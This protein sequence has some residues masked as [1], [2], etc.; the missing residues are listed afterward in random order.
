MSTV[1]YNEGKGKSVTTE[2]KLN[3]YDSK[4]DFLNNSFDC[5][6]LVL[7]KDA[8]LPN[9]SVKYYGTSSLWW[10][11]ARFNGIVYPYSQVKAGVGIYIPKL[12]QLMPYL[13]QQGIS[14]SRE[15]TL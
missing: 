6:Y 11:I 14:S 1:S 12:N 8:F 15:V 5:T 3:I 10:V 9:L 13:N 4:L 2:Y 7:E